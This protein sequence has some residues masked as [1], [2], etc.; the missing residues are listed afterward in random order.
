MQ[1]FGVEQDAAHQTGEI[2]ELDSLPQPGC[3]SVKGAGRDVAHCERM[4]DAAGH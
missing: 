2:L 3:V 4:G 1:T